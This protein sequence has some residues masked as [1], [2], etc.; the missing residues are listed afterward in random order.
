ML[1]SDGMEHSMFSP[2]PTLFGL[3]ATSMGPQLLSGMV[4]GCSCCLG[5]GPQRDP[6]Q[7]AW[8]M[9]L[10]RMGAQLADQHLKALMEIAAL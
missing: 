2:A 3:E 10:G 9:A 7:A 4:L 5:M 8:I 6:I 1:G